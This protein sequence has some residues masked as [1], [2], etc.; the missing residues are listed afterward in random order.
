MQMQWL[1]DQILKV[2]NYVPELL[3]GKDDPRFDFLRW[4]LLFVVVAAL[5]YLAV[6][7]RRAFRPGGN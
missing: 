4:W 5:V 6:M 1:A 2:L 7:V 3:L